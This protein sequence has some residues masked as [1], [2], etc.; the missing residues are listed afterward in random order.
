MQQLNEN[1]FLD[2]V[3]NIPNNAKGNCYVFGLGP[4][5]G[6]GGYYK[7][8]TQKARPGDKCKSEIKECCYRTIPFD[9]KNCDEFTKRIVC[10]N[11]KYVKQLPINCSW[12]RELPHGC[13][14]MAAILSPTQ[15][16]DFHFL[17]RFDIDQVYKVWSKLK[18]RTPEPARSEIESLFSIRRNHRKQASQ[19]KM[20]NVPRIYVWAHQRGWMEGGP[21]LC[22]AKN[23]IIRNIRTS[24]F[25]YEGLNY[26]IF[27]RYFQVL[28]RYTSVTKEF[29]K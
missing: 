29:D 12:E 17:R 18:H 2:V 8:R 7:H 27:C 28:T 23:N 24:N 21:V 5:V 14:M 26:K 11:P 10:D 25:D 22:D 13:H 3:W 15:H 1:K 20:R 4:S 16:K 9:F 19:G 6:K